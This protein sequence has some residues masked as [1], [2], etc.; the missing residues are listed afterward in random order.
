MKFLLINT[1]QIVQKLVEIT[2]KKAGADLTTIKDS[3][4]MGDLGQ[5]DYIIIDDDCLNLDKDKYLDALKDKRKCLIHNKQAKRIEGFDDYVQKP[6]LPTSILDVFTAQLANASTAPLQPQANEEATTAPTDAPADIPEQEPIS[7]DNLDEGL[8]EIDSLLEEDQHLDTPEAQEDT[9]NQEST[10][11]IE[12]TSND[13][14]SNS[15]EIGFDLEEV[16]DETREDAPPADDGLDIDLDF[17][18]FDKLQDPAQA[19]SSSAGD[20]AED[21][22]DLS[23]SDNVSEGNNEEINLE[24][25][26]ILEDEADLSLDLNTDSEL[27]TSAEEFLSENINSGE[28]V[29]DIPPADPIPMSDELNEEI[30]A[31]DIPSVES[32][33]E[34]AD[35]TESTEEALDLSAESEEETSLENDLFDDAEPLDLGDS[36]ALGDD[37]SDLASEGENSETD[38]LDESAESAQT[39]E[40]FEDITES[41]EDSTEDSVDSLDSADTDSAA[42]EDEIDLGE[43]ATEDATLENDLFDDAEPLDLGDSDALGDDVSDLA[44]EGENSETDALDESAESAQTDES[45]EDITESTEESASLESEDIANDEASLDETPSK[46][47]DS[48]QVSE[49]AQALDALDESAESAEKSDFVTLKEPEVAQALGEEIEGYEEENAQSAD[50]DEDSVA[51]SDTESAKEESDIA[52]IAKESPANNEASSVGETQ[53]AQIVKNMIASS[54]QSGISSL[55]SS[56]L[57]SM[58]DGL[59]VTINISFKDKSK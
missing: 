24:D 46:V 18:N 35:S 45:F 15:R 4:E 39:D 31:L 9:E 22:L 23:T 38:A 28:D 19:D 3:S 26:S 10:P 12:N 47:L 58:L 2:A 50:S 48:E 8:G 16:I 42:P 14:E 1:N 13:K 41:T 7:L 37:V 51:I 30:E 34:P 44:S 11:D 54:V 40:S 55:S 29:G 49:V 5:Y 17:T 59:E 21:A 36:D 20:E 43:N 33:D 53:E 57:K 56:N 27:G 52:P 6:F 32:E 25:D